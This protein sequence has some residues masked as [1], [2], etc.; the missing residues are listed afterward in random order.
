ML[1]S[2]SAQ[3]DLI[4]VT[5]DADAIPAPL[6]SLR[7]AIERAEST[8]A[9]DQIA[10]A[11]NVQAITL[12]A[13][14]PDITQGLLTIG[15]PVPFDSN[16]LEI[17]PE[18]TISGAGNITHALK[19][20]GPEVGLH[21]LGFE[22]FIGDAAVE[23]FVA[24]TSIEISGCRF[25]GVALGNTHAGLSIR[26]NSVTN[27][28]PEIDVR[29]SQFFSNA[30]GLEV[31]IGL[32][33]V[34]RQNLSI[35]NNRFG[36][37]QFLGGSL[38]N[39]TALA[40][41][42]GAW[43]VTNNLVTGTGNGFELVGTERAIV[44]DNKFGQLGSFSTACDGPDLGLITLRAA[45]QAVI[46][47]NQVRC[48]LGEGIRVLAGSHRALVRDNRIAHEWF[49][50]PISGA[51]IIVEDALDVVVR[52]N[53]VRSDGLAVDVRG[54]A[55]RTAVSCNA[56]YGAIA[57]L[58]V[59]PPAASPPSVSAASPLSAR[60]SVLDPDQGWVELFAGP[61]ANGIRFYGSHATAPN[62]ADL[63]VALEVLDLRVQNAGNTASIAWD[64]SL[65]PVV[66]ATRWRPGVNSSE[67][68]LAISMNDAHYLFDVIR[69]SV[70]AL[71][72]ANDGSVDLGPVDCLADD[73][74]PGMSLLVTDPDLP[75]AGESFFYVVRRDT[76]LS[77]RAGS[78]DP[79]VCGLD[80]HSFQGPR[81]ASSGDCGP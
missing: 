43:H 63:S 14:L 16:Q 18:V 26:V 7:L 20:T 78:Y 4:K 58:Q 3:A 25:G 48:A 51:G 27:L 61:S 50:A 35:R 31:K 34:V 66:T 1:V 65:D 69:G 44:S 37:P 53:R 46:E 33:S 77:P 19:I 64:E 11:D 2:V 59:T 13:P 24:P 57:P 40:L 42:N 73:R 38:S 5:T 45:P 9:A 75:A 68:G 21:R 71:S 76:S 60:I 49:D 32:P 54:N 56:L 79:A 70:G 41:S 67:P 81:R 62:D 74:V 6:G 17:A 30:R 12:V 36:L 80:L 23:Y 22:G 55:E 10:F 15:R 29:H 39:G 72:R 52:E 47:G 8:L 28:P